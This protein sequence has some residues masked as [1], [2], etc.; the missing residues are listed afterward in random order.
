MVDCSMSIFG[1]EVDCIR[2]SQ[3]KVSNIFSPRHS[4]LTRRM[5]ASLS[6]GSLPARTKLSA[7]DRHASAIM[8]LP[9]WELNSFYRD[10]GFPSYK[11]L[12]VHAAGGWVARPMS[13]WVWKDA[14]DNCGG[15]GLVACGGV[16]TATT[17]PAVLIG[18]LSMLDD[19]FGKRSCLFLIIMT[20]QRSSVGNWPGLGTYEIDSGTKCTYPLF[21]GFRVLRLPDRFYE[22]PSSIAK[23]WTSRPGISSFS[24]PSLYCNLLKHNCTYSYVCFMSLWKC[25]KLVTNWPQTFRGAAWS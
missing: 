8:K 15:L 2:D 4:P 7:I 5:L 9:A 13:T 12:L 20:E 22:R 17:A 3:V 23:Q 11:S 10:L 18:L 16:S 25:H 14:Q 19:G 24:C 21:I 1:E 6:S